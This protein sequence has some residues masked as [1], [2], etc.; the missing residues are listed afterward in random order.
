MNAKLSVTLAILGVVLAV[1]PLFAA[2]GTVT[3]DCANNQGV[4]VRTGQ[5]ASA[6]QTFKGPLDQQLVNDLHL[7][8]VR[9]LFKMNSL[10][11]WGG[12]TLWDQLNQAGADIIFCTVHGSIPGDVASCRNQISTLQSWYPDMEIS[13][14]VMNEPDLDG[15]DIGDFNA[16]YHRIAEAVAQINSPNVKVGGCAMAE[17]HWWDQAWYEKAFLRYV[18]D[19]QLR[20]DFYTYHDYLHEPDY[21]VRH[22]SCGRAVR[23]LLNQTGFRNLPV[24]IT[25]CGH[26]PWV[27]YNGTSPGDNRV[28]AHSA[29]ACYFWMEAGVAAANHF[30]LHDY[31]GSTRSVLTAVKTSGQDGKVNARYNVLWMWSRLKANRVAAAGTPIQLDPSISN[32]YL[33]WQEYSSATGHGVAAIGTMDETGVAVMFWNFQQ[34][35]W[36]GYDVTV[37]VQNLPANF[38]QG[39]VRMERYLIDATHSNYANDPDRDKLE[40]VENTVLGPMSTYSSTV[41][42]GSQQRLSCRTDARCWRTVDRGDPIDLSLRRCDGRAAPGDRLRRHHTLHHRWHDA[43]GLFGDHAPRT[44]DLHMRRAAGGETRR[45]GKRCSGAFLCVEH[46]QPC[47]GSLHGSCRGREEGALPEVHCR[48]HEIDRE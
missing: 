16:S 21:V 8:K 9:V 26:T 6:I 22:L 14:E 35:G 13:I 7:Q 27:D 1:E 4:L 3:V 44:L 47:R 15:V 25:E 41:A 46:T 23:A 30:A 39:N 40:K 48:Q 18:I 17:Y 19:N 34:Y 33:G 5:N 11:G 45:I 36:T 2:P 20:L 42:M 43:D 12:K 29:A 31:A 37:S 28:A 38:S 32:Y 24:Y 10:D